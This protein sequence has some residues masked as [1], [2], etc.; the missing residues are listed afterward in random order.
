MWAPDL[1][2][3][4]L[5]KRIVLLLPGIRIRSVRYQ[6]TAPFELSRLPIDLKNPYELLK[7]GAAITGVHLKIFRRIFRVDVFCVC[8]PI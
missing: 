4:L 6:P 1:V 5:E 3:W 2:W 8:G 7:F